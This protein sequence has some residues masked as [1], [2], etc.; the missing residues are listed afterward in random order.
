M[1]QNRVAEVAYNLLDA[2]KR[3]S[4]DAD[5]ELFAKVM[6][7]DCSET[8]L[9]QQ[10]KML[11]EVKKAIMETTVQAGKVPGTIEK[12]PGAPTK[13]QIIQVCREYP[14][15]KQYRE[16]SF[17]QLREKLEIDAPKDGQVAW[18]KLF[19]EDSEGN[20]YAFVE[21][22]RDLILSDRDEYFD[23]LEEAICEQ[24]LES[25][26]LVNVQELRAAVLKI[27]PD[28]LPGDVDA[29]I[30]LG[31]MM[32]KYKEEVIEEVD[33]EGNVV[34]SK[35]ERVLISR[36]LIHRLQELPHEAV[37]FHTNEFMS[38]V[39]KHPIQRDSPPIEQKVAS[40]NDEDNMASWQSPDEEG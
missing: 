15:M 25:D 4:Y 16:S 29:L 30:R 9:K 3:Y 2:C 8:V 6:R 21:C 31:L 10:M 5:I 27:D 12:V 39:R 7:G 37:E 19:E 26:G 33:E 34:S 1:P 36:T 14:M 28:K 22:L 38:L 24:D 17:E 18:Q 40:L 11:R 23:Q 13:D 20:Q 32:E 35:T